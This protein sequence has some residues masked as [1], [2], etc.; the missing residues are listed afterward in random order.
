VAL[1]YAIA[2]GLW[3]LGSDWLVTQLVA[4]AELRQQVSAVKGWL[5][6]GITSTLLFTLLRGRGRAASAVPASAG[7]S[8]RSLWTAAALALLIGAVTLQLVRLREARYDAALARQLES[9]A[10]LRA[11]EVSNWLHTRHEHARQASDCLPCARSAQQ[12]LERR[13]ETA[14][15]WLQ[16]QLAQ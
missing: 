10:E 16:S 3:I 14:R 8:R 15:I 7:F 5:F 9:V 1:T 12:W 13:D 11:A 2:G 6:I 4:D